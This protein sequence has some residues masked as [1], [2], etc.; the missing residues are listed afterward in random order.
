MFGERRY[1]FVRKEANGTV[2]I[3]HDSE[4]SSKTKVVCSTCNNGWMSVLETQIQTITGEM[5]T[6]CT[7]V[8]LDKDQM[9]KLAAFAF[10]KGVIADHSHETRPPFYS[11][12]ERQTFRHSL[13]IPRGVQMWLASV[14]VPQGIFKNMTV[15]APQ[16]TPGR[17][18]LNVFTY[19]LGHLLIQVVGCQ[20]KKKAN[21]RYLPPPFVTQNPVWDNVSTPF[22]P[23]QKAP[24]QW[25]PKAH[26]GP[27]AVDTFVVRWKDMNLGW[28][29]AAT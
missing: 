29:H 28:M 5:V 3:W 24:I 7:A 8:S 1:D 17:F 9:G 22:W 25:P 16:N 27:D 10:M 18:G 6:K 12:E 4:L 20:W 21:R 23:D 19:G 14:P 26:M 11:F 15:E 13:L 2:R